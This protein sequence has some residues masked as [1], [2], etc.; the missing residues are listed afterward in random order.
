MALNGI[1]FNGKRKLNIE[2]AF[3]TSLCKSTKDKIEQI[4]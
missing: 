1:N 2:T 3:A 4:T